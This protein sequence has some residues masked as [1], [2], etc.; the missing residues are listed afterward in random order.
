MKASVQNFRKSLQIGRRW[1]T[2]KSTHHDKVWIK[3]GDNN[4]ENN[5][6]SFCIVSLQAD[7]DGQRHTMMQTWVKSKEL[8]AVDNE[9]Y[10]KI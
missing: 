3:D 5:I 4:N 1:N 2:S 9:C 8:N 6:I 7:E 10:S